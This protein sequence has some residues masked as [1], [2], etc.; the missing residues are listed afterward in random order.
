MSRFKLGTSIIN[1]SKVTT[2]LS[3]SITGNKLDLGKKYGYPYVCLK[4]IWGEWMYSAIHSYCISVLDE[5]S[6]QPHTLAS[7]LP[8]KHPPIPTE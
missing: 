7:V 4:G 5:V 1:V 8:G 6:G 3:C 2:D